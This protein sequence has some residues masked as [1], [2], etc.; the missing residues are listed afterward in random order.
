[1]TEKS[2]EK[3]LLKRIFK[4]KEQDEPTTARDIEK[5]VIEQNQSAK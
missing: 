5:I 3:K 1:M 2:S 4:T